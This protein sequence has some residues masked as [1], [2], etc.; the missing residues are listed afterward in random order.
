MSILR[1]GNKEAAIEHLRND[2]VKQRGWKESGEKNFHFT[3]PSGRHRLTVSARIVR[4]FVSSK[5]DLGRTQWAPR[6]GTVGTTH[7]KYLANIAA[8]AAAGEGN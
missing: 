4:A 7:K 8:S 3:S 1:P 6:A 2:L 5:D